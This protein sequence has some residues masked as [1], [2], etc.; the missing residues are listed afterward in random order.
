V[1]LVPIAVLGA[2]VP[3]AEARKVV[4]EGFGPLQP[5]PLPYPAPK[6]DGAVV[7]LL[8]EQI[9][10][11]LSNL[12]NDHAGDTGTATRE[13]RD[14]FA[15][16][17]AA[18]VA[19]L[20]RYMGRLPGWNFRI[21][22]KPTK[23][24]EFRHVRFA[25]K[26][27]GGTGAMVQFFTDRGWEQRYVAGPNTVNW[28][29]KSV[30]AKAPAE[31]EVVTRDL[32]A[33]FGAI[34]VFGFAMTPMDGTALLFDHFLLGR[35]VAD[36]DAA[37]AAAL[38]KTKPEKPLAGADRDAAWA[39]LLGEDR[40]KAAAALRQFL[41]AAPDQVEYVAAHLPKGDPAVGA[42]VIRL[43]GDLD[44][45]DFDARQKAADE[46]AKIGPA[47]VEMLQTAAQS[48]P[49][50]EVRYRAADIL[51]GKAGGGVSKAAV[52]ARF[53]RVLERAGTDEAKAVLAKLAAGEYG[54]EYAD[55]ARTAAARLGKG[56]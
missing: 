29:A 5:A 53:V 49:S 20:Q 13:D 7:S 34:T 48:S 55:D 17:E 8:D 47:A 39:D 21:V 46:L 43:I 10:P 52:G 37:T 15:G 25:W 12:L 2:L 31:W 22:E 30:S 19:P 23:P 42:R 35:S 27:L 18:R 38:G 24:G 41:A 51:R 11:L 4:V 9:D 44:A 56:R 1:W 36:L 54:P 33:D 32:F 40:V 3:A 50:D 6:A 16:V 28:A 14:V 45:A 26:K